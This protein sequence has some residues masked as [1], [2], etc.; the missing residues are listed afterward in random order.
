M[1]GLTIGMMLVPQSIAYTH[2]AGLPV[3]Y[4][5]YSSMIGVMVYALFGTAKDINVGP[6]AAL[7]LYIG[8]GIHQIIQSHAEL[9]TPTHMVALASIL[10]LVTGG[11]ITL[12]GLLRIGILLDFISAPIVVGFTFG[13]GLDI[14]LT[15]IPKLLGV[16][17]V[18]T[19]GS[20]FNTIYE[21]ASRLKFASLANLAVGFTAMLMILAL[22]AI[23]E[24][25]GARYKVARIVGIARIGITVVFYTFISFLIAVAG[26]GDNEETGQRHPLYILRRVP[27]GL[28]TPSIPSADGVLFQQ[29]LVA[30]ILPFLQTIIEHITMSKALSK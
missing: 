9:N 18:N 26:H 24:R 27:H 30:S 5:L 22:K 20:T 16:A 28:P 12:L 25:Y 17:G 19:N 6:T 23:N 14:M 13:A 29:L 7:S 11:L 15:Q 8:Q 4:G 3:E 2:L 1:A 21:L 10:A